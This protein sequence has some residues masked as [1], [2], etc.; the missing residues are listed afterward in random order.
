[1]K[2]VIAFSVVAIVIIGGGVGYVLFQ[3]KEPQTGVPTEQTKEISQ[4]AQ[5]IPTPSTPVPPSQDKKS[6]DEPTSVPQTQIQDP[7]KA[8]VSYAVVY[9][10]A[11]F[12]PPSLEIKK[13]DTVTFENGSTKGMWPASAM[14]PTHREY[15]TTG[16]CIGSTFDA[17][18]SILPKEEWSFTFDKVGSW[19]YHNHVNSSHYGSIIIK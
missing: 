3:K 12:L 18:K 9:T 8:F 13:G 17:C 10:D 11:G 1:M 7:V 16:G 2:K 14:H 15:P 19:R 6:A 5:T 4:Q